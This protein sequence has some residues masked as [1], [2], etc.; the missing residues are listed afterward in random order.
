MINVEEAFSW[1]WFSCCSHGTLWW[2]QLPD[3][4]ADLATYISAWFQASA[5]KWLRTA[6]FCIVTQRVVLIPYRPR[7]SW[8]L[9]MGLIDCPETSAVNYRYT[10][11]N[12]REERSSRRQSLILCNSRQAEGSNDEMSFISPHRNTLYAVCMAYFSFLFELLF[13]W[14]QTDGNVIRVN[15]AISFP[16]Y[17]QQIFPLS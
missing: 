11:R 6:L 5:A 16:T 14:N 13:H 15:S 4:S 9:R 12:S 2:S 7:D 1:E 8:T 3:S 17:K 10:L